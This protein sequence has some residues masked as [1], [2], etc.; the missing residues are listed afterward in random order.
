MKEDT[1]LYGENRKLT[2]I[3]LISS[4]LYMRRC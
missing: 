2:V 1:V 3:H 4:V